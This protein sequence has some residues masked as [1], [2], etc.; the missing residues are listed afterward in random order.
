MARQFVLLAFVSGCAA[1][2]PAV[3]P[4]VPPVDSRDES[5]GAAPTA[6]TQQIDGVMQA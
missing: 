6:V 3:T 1:T 4:S 2:R 5:Q